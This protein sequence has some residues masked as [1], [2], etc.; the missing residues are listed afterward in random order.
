[1]VVVEN[2]NARVVNSEGGDSGG[3]EIRKYSQIHRHIRC[4]QIIECR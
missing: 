4:G 2:R 3:T 1:M